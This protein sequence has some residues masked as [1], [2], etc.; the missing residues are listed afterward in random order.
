MP[1]CVYVG[2]TGTGAQFR[3]VKFGAFW[4]ERVNSGGTTKSIDGR[5]IRYSIPGYGDL[6]ADA[7]SEGIYTYRLV[8]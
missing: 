8:G 5:F 6:D 7:T 2:G 1:L 4:L 3:I